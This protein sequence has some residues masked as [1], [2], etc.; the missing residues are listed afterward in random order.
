MNTI[1]RSLLRILYFSIKHLR[2]YIASIID[3]PGM[4]SNWFSI[5]STYVRI[6]LSFTLSYDNIMI[7]ATTL[8]IVLILINLYILSLHSFDILI[9]LNIVLNSFVNDR[10][11][12]HHYT[13]INTWSWL[14]TLS[15]PILYKAP[16]TS[17]LLK[18]CFRK[19]FSY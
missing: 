12:K 6:L 16:L 3:L 4:K 7:I 17:Y 1:C 13:S 5:T 19:S 11:P 9:V 18:G 10:L 14:V 15:L 2:R 8:S